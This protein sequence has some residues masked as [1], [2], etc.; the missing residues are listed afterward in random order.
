MLDEAV[1]NQLIKL[2]KICFNDGDYADFFFENRLPEIKIYMVENEG[3]ILSACYARFFDLV[4]AGKQI[5]IPFLTGVATSPNHR[6]KGYAR[7]VVLKAKN[8]LTNEGYPF[9][10]LHPFNHDFYRKLGFETINYITRIKPSKSAKEKVTFRAMES[11]DIPL[12]STLYDKFIARNSSYK[13]RDEREIELLIGNSLKHGG[14]GYL[15]YESG[16]P[17]GYVWCEDGVCAEGIAERVELFDG[18][19][20]PEEY[21][22]PLVG[23][24]TD[25][26]MGAILS[27]DELLKIVP[28]L[29]SVTKKISFQ[30]DGINYILDIT[31]GKFKSLTT[32]LSSGHPITEREIISICLGHGARQENNPFKEVIPSYDLAC[33]EIY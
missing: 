12:V 14:F 13:K 1:K 18:V 19:P 3:E 30:L 15:I 6:Y 2:H 10:M 16:E 4:L 11:E 20:L 28:I 17:R 33:Y 5:R 24:N 22:I 21:S 27:L 7:E 23:G 32:T 25:Y 29:P 8:E 26:S 9:V 31:E